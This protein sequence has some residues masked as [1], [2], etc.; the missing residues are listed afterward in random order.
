MRRFFIIVFT[1]ITITSLVSQSNEVF[2]PFVS[3][4]SVAKQEDGIL[5]SWRDSDDVSDEEYL[6]YR[7]TEEITEQNFENAS[8]VATV[9]SD[10]ESYIDYPAPGSEY[11]Y[12]VINRT[13]DNSVYELFIPYRNKTLTGIEPDTIVTE[14]ELA[15]SI[16]E[17]EAQVQGD[18]I[19]ISFETSDTDRQIT[20][21]R[22]TSPIISRQDLLSANALRTISSSQNSFQDFPIPGVSYF[23]A[24]LDTG[25]VQIGRPAL[26]EGTNTLINPVTIPLSVERTGLP[27]EVTQRDMPLPLLMLSTEVDTGLELGSHSYVQLPQQVSVSDAAE[28]AVRTITASMSVPPAPIPD[29]TL[30]PPERANGSDTGDQYLLYEIAQNY[31]LEEQW[32]TAQSELTSFLSMNR[33]DSVEDRARFYLGLAHYYNGNLRGAFVEMLA[34]KTEYHLYVQPWLDRLYYELRTGNDQSE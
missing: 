7:H 28:Q 11:Y 21:Y 31:L 15:V 9:D 6:I 4:L 34:A 33:V 3:R 24:V 32:E 29:F 10:E 17:L 22:N 26:S 18:S 14:E 30:L 5:I 13:S 1:F 23:Y 2:A 27:T 25:L 16:T 12:L 20:I 8:L 19:H